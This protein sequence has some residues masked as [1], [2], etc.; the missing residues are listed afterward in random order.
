MTTSLY[1]SN[2]SVDIVEGIS[3]KKSITVKRAINKELE[4]GTI[5]NGSIIEENAIK[6]VI[7]EIYDENKT[8]SKKIKLVVDSSSIYTKLLTVPSLS[9]N[10]LQE[11]VKENFKELEDYENL[12]YD[13]MTIDLSDKTKGIT[14]LACAVE[15]DFIKSYVNI[16]KELKI[17]IKSINIS[18]A[19]GISLLSMFTQL[20]GKNYVV[21][22]LDK[23]SLT[24]ILFIDGIYTYQNRVRLVEERGTDKSIIEIINTIS[25]LIQF[26]KSERGTDKPIEEMF[27]C[28][29]IDNEKG[30]LDE[31]KHSLSIDASELETDKNIK[32]NGNEKCDAKNHFYTIGNLI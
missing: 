11:I 28:G 26:N 21:S 31:I 16:F 1:I 32:F 17:D 14:I 5:I 9:D 24:N 8:L 4:D 18:L 27:F 23:N 3:S 22:T 10:K 6:D 20:N 13:Y 2:G 7:K 15:R 29:L 30:I 25:S 12:I 19:C